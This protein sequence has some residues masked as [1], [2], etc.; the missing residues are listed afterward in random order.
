MSVNSAFFNFVGEYFEHT[1][2]MMG[3]GRSCSPTRSADLRTIDNRSLV[4]TSVHQELANIL[5]RA[6]AYSVDQR[7]LGV[8]SVYLVAW[9][10]SQYKVSNA[11]TVTPHWNNH[12]LSCSIQT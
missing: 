12:Q 8:S 11:L 9:H 1:M 5:L 6:A 2:H 7:C 3:N 4:V 10:N